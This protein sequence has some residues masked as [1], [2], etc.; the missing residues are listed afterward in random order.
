[1]PKSKHRRKGKTRPRVTLKAPAP[2]PP[3]DS[4][5]ER[6]QAT[7][8]SP[9][10]MIA[11]VIDHRLCHKCGVVQ[12]VYAFFLPYGHHSLNTDGGNDDGQWQPVDDPVFL[13][14]VTYLNENAICAMREVAGASYKIDRDPIYGQHYWLNHCDECDALLADWDDHEEPGGAFNLELDIAANKMSLYEFNQ[15]FEAASD[16]LSYAEPYNT[17]ATIWE[18]DR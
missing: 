18:M 3:I 1:M 14:R 10:F 16:G 9:K 7:V 17:V 15:P 11:E 6:D 8:R 13:S 12:S 2:I 5:Y 4:E